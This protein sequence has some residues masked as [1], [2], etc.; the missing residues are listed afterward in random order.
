MPM[1]LLKHVVV[2]VFAL[3]L[4]AGPALVRPL[5]ETESRSLNETVEAFD[6]AM[7]DHDYET[8]VKTIPPRVLAHIAKSAGVD[9]DTLRT[10]VIAEMKAAL[11]EVKLVSF[12]MDLAKAEHRELPS[13][14]PYV[15]VPT[16]TVIDAAAGKFVGRSYTLAMLDDG[17]WYLVRVDE[18]Q[19]VTIMR[20]VY[21]EFAEVEFPAGSVEATE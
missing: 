18:A 1:T 10:L 13:G 8:V 16:E 2:A 17:D 4:A 12:G 3:L 9:V 19:Q 6:A 14:E 11:A 5:S 20:E 7:R 21:P 15:L